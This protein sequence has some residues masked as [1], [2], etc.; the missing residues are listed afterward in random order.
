[1]V[2]DDDVP[3]IAD[4]LGLPGLFDIHVHFMPPQILRKVWASFDAAGPKVGR[5]WPIT[6]RGTDDDRLAQ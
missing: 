5:P 3:G 4:N 6:Y 1:M 2:H